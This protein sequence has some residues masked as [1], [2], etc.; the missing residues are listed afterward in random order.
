MYQSY[1]HDFTLLHGD[2]FQLL[3]S[4]SFKFDMIFAD[5]PYFLSNFLLLVLALC[6]LQRRYITK[7]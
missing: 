6:L 1:N 3:P 5:P 7:V 2:T 4:F